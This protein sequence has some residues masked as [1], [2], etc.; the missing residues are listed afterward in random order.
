[1]E[2]RYQVINSLT[3]ARPTSS[4]AVM[5]EG[6]FVPIKLSEIAVMNVEDKLCFL[7]SD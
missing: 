3:R 1:M 5:L 6:V 4:A 2:H 7:F